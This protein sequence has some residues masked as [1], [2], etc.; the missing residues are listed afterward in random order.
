LEIQAKKRFLINFVYLLV[1]GLTV[2]IISRFLLFRMFPFILSIIVAALSQ[3]PAAFLSQKTGVKKSF[4]AVVLSAVIYLGLCAGIIF[5]IYRL[6][7]SSSG[8]IDFLPQILTTFSSIINK[9]EELITE[10]IPSDI[11]FSLSGLIQNVLE[12]LTK[13]LTEIIKK[14]LTAMPSIFVSGIVAL[15][16]ACYIS[17]DYDGLSRFVKSL[18]GD[19]IYNRFLRIKTIFTNGVF[20]MLKGYFILMVITFFELWIGFLILKI[21]NAYFWAFLIALIDLLPILGTGIILVPWAIYCAV[22][23]NISVS[24]GLAVLYIIMVLVRNFCEPKIVSRQIG[25]NPLFIL[26][27]MYLGLKLFGGAG[28]ILLPIILMVTVQYYKQEE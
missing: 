2:I 25:I 3:K 23:G 1:I 5:L 10:Y 15:V 4:C 14:F 18:C 12:S 28:I 22:A 19:K 9:A 6:I 26:F 17:K 20:K 8:L 24:V 11:D 13:F 21:N 27:S 16:A 7:V